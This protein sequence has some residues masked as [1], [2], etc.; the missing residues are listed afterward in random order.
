[1]IT[2]AN[3]LRVETWIL[4]SPGARAT[5]LKLRLLRYC[6]SHRDVTIEHICIFI[7]PKTFEIN[8]NKSLEVICLV[9]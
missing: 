2:K 9:Q 8:Q 4:L 6:D 1:M 7:Q 3:A 5:E